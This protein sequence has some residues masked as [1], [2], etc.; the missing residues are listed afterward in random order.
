M[1]I[2]LELDAKKPRRLP[3]PSPLLSGF[4][5]FWKA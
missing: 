3:L 1:E 4:A 5:G 2:K